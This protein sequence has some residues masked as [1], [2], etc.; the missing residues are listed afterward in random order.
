MPTDIEQSQPEVN[1]CQKD[2]SKFAIICL[3]L[4]KPFFPKIVLTFH[5]SNKNCS[6]DHKNLQIHGLQPRITKVSLNH[7]FFSQEIRTIFETKYQN[8][9]LPELSANKF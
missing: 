1:F 5:C 7:N 9:L 6:S 4:K 2:Q 3:W 8:Q